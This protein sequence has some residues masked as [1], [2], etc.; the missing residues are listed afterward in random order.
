MQFSLN[1]FDPQ[2]KKIKFKITIVSGTS[3][4]VFFR[5]AFSEEE[6][7]SQYPDANEIK[8]LQPRE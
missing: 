6:I 1:A 3:K 8:T 5:D 7:R 4:N 2:A